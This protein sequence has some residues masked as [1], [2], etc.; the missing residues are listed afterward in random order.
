MLIEDAFALPEAEINQKLGN[1]IKY[2]AINPDGSLDSNSTAFYP[3]HWFDN[4]GKVT[5]WQVN[6]FI[7]SELDINDLQ[8]RIGQFPGACKNGDSVTI[9]QALIYRRSDGKSA[10]LTMKFNIYIQDETT[11]VEEESQ[12]KKLN[13]WPNPTSNLISWNVYEY[14]VLSD[15]HGVR[16]AS[17][18]GSSLDISEYQS[19][20]YLLKI[21]KDIFKVMKQ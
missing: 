13:I 12:N 17:G 7:Y 4:D 14:F 16:I 18:N 11:A 1:Q 15:V 5:R 21:G 2:Y 20:L 10:M 8:V 3:G 6:S 9:R 19:G